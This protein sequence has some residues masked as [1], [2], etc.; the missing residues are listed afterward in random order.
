M[1]L[2]EKFL[3]NKLFSRLARPL[4]Y[5]QF[6]GGDTE[7][8]LAKTSQALL[9]SN[10]RLM[11]CPVQEEDLDDSQDTDRYRLD[12]PGKET[13]TCMH[14]KF[15]LLPKKHGI[16]GFENKVFGRRFWNKMAEIK[17]KI[18]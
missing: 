1:K 12:Q 5:A 18:A 4:F 9:Q 7:Q 11:V 14:V 16:F 17:P 6:V 15:F 13:L 8:E 3:G 2:G 10:V